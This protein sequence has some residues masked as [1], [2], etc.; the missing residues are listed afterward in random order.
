MTPAGNAVFS[1]NT[2]T[3]TNTG[4]AGQDFGIAV[5]SEDG[6]SVTYTGNTFKSMYAYAYGDWNGYKNNTIGHNT[7]LGTP[8]YTFV[9]GDGA[10]DPTT[11]PDP[12]AVCPASFTFTDNLPNKVN[13]IPQSNATV[14]IADQITQCKASQ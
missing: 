12:I 9:A 2:V 11:G 3:T 6:T 13:C 10:C 14:T 5:D 7:W 1:G 4:G 8:T